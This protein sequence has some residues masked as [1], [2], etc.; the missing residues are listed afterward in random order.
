M[1]NGALVCLWMYMYIHLHNHRNL[2]PLRNVLIDIRF[3]CQQ[4]IFFMYY[5]V[6]LHECLAKTTSLFCQQHMESATWKPLSWES[7]LV[8]HLLRLLLLWK[9]V[10]F[11]SNTHKSTHMT[12]VGVFECTIQS[13]PIIVLLW[14]SLW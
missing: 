1:V 5:I 8:S 2:M 6:N 12:V 4:L 13:S 11:V 9:T 3:L 7:L 14:A 10:T